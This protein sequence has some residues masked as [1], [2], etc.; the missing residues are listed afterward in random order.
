MPEF[1][2]VD[3]L[4]RLS[5]EQVL[6]VDSDLT[7]WPLCAVSGYISDADL[8]AFAR[9]LFGGGVSRFG[10][11][12]LLSQYIGGSAVPNSAAI[13]LVVELVR[14]ASFPDRPSRLSSAFGTS[15]LD[16][17]RRFRARHGTPFDPVF[18]VSCERSFRCDSDLLRKGQS[19]LAAW[20]FATKYWRGEQ[21][22]N[23]TWEEI[24]V[25]PVAV[26]ERVE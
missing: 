14:R 7:G 12:Y 25:P 26:M 9:D 5:P 3:R 1:F 19:L 2:T 18:R 13:E 6:G 22:P 10:K 23:P 4:Q 16:E 17:A 24:L 20:L 11:D 21:G 15:T 8:E